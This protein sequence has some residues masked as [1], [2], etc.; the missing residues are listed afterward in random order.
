VNGSPSPVSL[1]YSSSTSIQATGDASAVP[2]GS[3]LLLTAA[4]GGGML[5]AAAG[6]GGLVFGPKKLWPTV[7]TCVGLAIALAATVQ[8]D[9]AASASPGS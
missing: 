7:L 8:S 3:S 2:V 6:V 5:V 9:S 4:A 1:L